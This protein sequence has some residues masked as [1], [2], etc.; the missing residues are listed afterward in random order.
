MERPLFAL[1]I[2]LLTCLSVAGVARAQTPPPGIA[3][4]PVSVPM[5]VQASS[6]RLPD[7]ATT[8]TGEKRTFDYIKYSYIECRVNPLQVCA[9][10][11]VID[12]PNAYWQICTSIFQVTANAGDT[13]P[14]SWAADKWFKS[15]PIEPA[16]FRRY[17]VTIGA[18]GKWPNTGAVMRLEN[19]G[20]R[21]I[22]ADA[23]QAERFAAGCDIFLDH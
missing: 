13:T 6:T 2:Q 5:Q 14:P 3:P 17:G 10:T 1:A 21:V 8:S 16:G 18:R 12:V 15:D 9:G 20:V 7:V 23:N 19:V 11:E 22:P 4:K